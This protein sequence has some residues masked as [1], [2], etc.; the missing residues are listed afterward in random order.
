MFI[1]ITAITTLVG[2]LVM[3]GAWV[4]VGSRI[5]QAHTATLRPV[6]L[7]HKFFLHMAIFFLLM[8][9]PHLWITFDPINF[10][11]PMAIGYTFGH[12]FLYLAFIDIA[13]MTCV[14]VPK[15]ASKERLA[16]LVGYAL[17][18]VITTINAITMIWGKQPTFDYANNVTLF[19]AHP[20]VG[21]SIGILAAVSVL[22][23]A[24]L[25]IINAFKSHSTR[26]VR[27][28]LLGTGFF[29]LMTAGPLHD[30]ARTSQLYLIAD[31]F[32]M[33]SIVLVG[34]GVVY[35]LEQSLSLSSPASA[36]APAPN[37]I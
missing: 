11:L 5:R 25:F 4:F 14:I 36:K 19:N 12:I 23:A 2:V 15:L 34:I 8:W 3:F 30:V 20:I 35:R 27:S 26:R 16:T 37:A 32:S 21:A 9:A 33:V 13:Q 6:L 7:L 31:I 18:V 22:P 17:C 1:P 24:V 29:L 10:S 28:L